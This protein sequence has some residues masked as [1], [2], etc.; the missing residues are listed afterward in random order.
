MDFKKSY[1]EAKVIHED[2]NIISNYFEYFLKLI[3]PLI[4]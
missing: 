2:E 3:D 1:L 4:S